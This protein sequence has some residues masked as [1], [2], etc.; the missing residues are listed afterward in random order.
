MA[1]IIKETITTAS[2]NMQSPVIVTPTETTATKSQSM[3]YIIYYLFGTLE[4]LLAFRMILKLMGASFSSFFVR[5]IYSVT[6]MFI[7]PFEGI[8]RRSVTQGLETKS[9]LEPSAFVAVIVY[10]ILAWGIVKLLRIATGKTQPT[11]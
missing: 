8:F 10:P 11:E 3:E 9:V 5:V 6:G 2:N 4:I 7:L 1:E